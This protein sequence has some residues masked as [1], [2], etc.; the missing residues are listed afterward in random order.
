[1]LNLLL[2]GLAEATASG[3]KE[4]GCQ[5][6]RSADPSVDRANGA[7]AVSQRELN[8]RSTDDGTM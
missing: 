1:M 8:R 3:C 6:N 2:A 5:S 4:I 7:A